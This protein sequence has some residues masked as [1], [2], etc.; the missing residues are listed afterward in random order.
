ME[1]IKNNDELRKFLQAKIREHFDTFMDVAFNNSIIKVM[2]IDNDVP[3]VKHIH[4]NSKHDDL[5]I[6]FTDSYNLSNIPEGHLWIMGP[7]EKIVGFVIEDI[8]VKI[9]DRVIEKAH[10]KMNHYLAE[11][12]GKNVR[13][14]NVETRKL[15]LFQDLLSNSEQLKNLTFA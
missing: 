15:N 6:L 10:K 7:E 9:T 14:K 12:S 2:P 4:Y 1:D 11:I 3:R 13:H 5:F 8:S